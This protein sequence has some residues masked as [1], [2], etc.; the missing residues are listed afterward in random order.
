MIALLWM[1]ASL[2]AAP[3]ARPAVEVAVATE[4]DRAMTGLRLPGST[5]PYLVQYEVLDGEDASSS[6]GR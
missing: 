3:E 6:P 2:A 1:G 5:T 4:L